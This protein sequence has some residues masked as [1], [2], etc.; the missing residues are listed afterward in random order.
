M[1][2][3]CK[4]VCGTCSACLHECAKSMCMHADMCCIGHVSQQH[5]KPLVVTVV[6]VVTVGTG[7]LSFSPPCITYSL[8]RCRWR[9]LHS[10][11]P[12]SARVRHSYRAT[13][14][15][16]HRPVPLGGG[17]RPMSDVPSADVRCAVGRCRCASLNRIHTS[18][19]EG[20]SDFAAEVGQSAVFFSD[21]CLRAWLKV[22]PD[23]EGG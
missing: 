6:T 10:N 15:R 13:D 18:R 21:R 19:G 3:A 16:R 17:R 7:A 4:W 5:W 11:I 8:R 23:A 22:V 1:Q 9:V 2:S 20:A 14:G 12:A